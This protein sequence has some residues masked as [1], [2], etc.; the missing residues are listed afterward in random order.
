MTDS[1][2]CD[3]FFN[4]LTSVVLP[5]V[6]YYVLT[7]LGYSFL[8]SKGKTLKHILQSVEWSF[9]KTEG[10]LWLGARAKFVIFCFRYKIS[11]TGIISSA[12]L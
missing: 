10:F 2:L 3:I 8:A 11:G 6:S 12:S 5:Y 7:N 1:H 4:L 9:W